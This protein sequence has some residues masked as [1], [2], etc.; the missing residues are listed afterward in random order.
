MKAQL[1]R[2]FSTILALLL[3]LASLAQPGAQATPATAVPVQAVGQE[4][5]DELMGAVLAASSQ[6]FKASA[7][8]YRAHSG[9]LDFSLDTGGLK[10]SGDSFAWGITLSGLGRGDQ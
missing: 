1:K 10:A 8:S 4:M 7:G 9:G 6:P 3:V 5:P 2:L